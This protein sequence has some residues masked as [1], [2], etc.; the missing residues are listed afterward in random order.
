MTRVK[1][2]TLLNFVW[3]CARRNLYGSRI[4][5]FEKNSNPDQVPYSKILKQEQSRSL[6]KWLQP[7]LITMYCFFSIG[8]ITKMY[9]FFSIVLITRTY[10]FFSI[11]SRCTLGHVMRLVV[12]RALLFFDTL[13]NEILL[14]SGS[15]RKGVVRRRTPRENVRIEKQGWGTW[16]T[17]SKWGK[18]GSEKNFLRPVV[19][20][21][22]SRW[23]HFC[24]PAKSASVILSRCNFITSMRRDGMW[25]IVYWLQ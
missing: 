16:E 22:K 2:K 8:L 13:V 11:A 15:E 19:F 12:W 18:S 14:V 21:A 6:E 17:T 5:K 7:P 9:Y 23:W 10:Y 25:C 20:F 24:W 1:D 3:I 4:L